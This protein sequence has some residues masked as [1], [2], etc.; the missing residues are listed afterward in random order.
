M[1]EATD[2]QGFR[3]VEGIRYRLDTSV[4][5]DIGREGSGWPLSLPEGFEFDSSVAI[6]V[7]WLIS[8]HRRRWLLAAAVHDIL[9]QNGFDKAFAAGEWY[10]CAV[11]CDPGNWL[12]RVAYLAIAWRTV[13]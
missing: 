2:Y 11:A 5:W 7:R 9:L 13:R 4:I 10:R 6:I 1:S 8:P 3:P 12:N